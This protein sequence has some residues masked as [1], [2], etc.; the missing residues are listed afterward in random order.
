VFGGGGGGGGG[1]DVALPLSFEI[2]TSPTATVVTATISRERKGRTREDPTTPG[3]GS[4]VVG[5][6]GS[7]GTNPD[8]ATTT[9]TETERED[10]PAGSL[11]DS[12]L[13]TLRSLRQRLRVG[14]CF[15][16]RC[17]NQNLFCTLGR[18]GRQEGRRAECWEDGRAGVQEDRR[19]GRADRGH[20]TEEGPA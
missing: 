9:A 20:R 7:D 19:E 12:P 13:P 18:L 4:R 1:N 11:G 8:E 15:S 2:H 14:F 17:R 10:E 3:D 16:L 6:G 5:D